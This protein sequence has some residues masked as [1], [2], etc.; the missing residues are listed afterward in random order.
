MRPASRHALVKRL[1]E[2]TPLRATGLWSALFLAGVAALLL[3]GFFGRSEPPPRL[4]APEPRGPPLLD[5]VL[6]LPFGEGAAAAMPPAPAVDN[7]RVE[8]LRTAFRT[9]DD[10]QSLYRQWRYRPEAD[11]RYLAFR[12]ARD[13]E[14][15]RAG[16]AL[17]E[18]E[19][20][21][22]RRGERERQMAAAAARCRGFTAEPAPPDEVQRLE[23]EAAAAGHPAAQIAL[24]TE[25]FTQRP[26]AETLAILQRGLASGDPLAFDEARL[27]L[28]MSRHQVEIAGMAPTATADVRRTDARVVAIDLVG[29][30]LGNPCGPN[31]GVVAIDCGSN[32]RCLRD[33]E[34]W[35]VQMADLNDEERRVALGLA[36]R[37]LAAFRRGAVDEIVRARPVE[38]PH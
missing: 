7:N 20:R 16:G 31:R 18:L 2:A 38:P 5:A 26:L 9:A 4:A 12:A 29:C 13:C 36:D 30:R 27:L 10:H 14:L 25:T 23:Q 3:V 24:A 11:A 35:V 8:D 32:G 19:T 21:S 33:A 34:E 17:G 6:A 28:A 15:L 22:E 37:M 1:T